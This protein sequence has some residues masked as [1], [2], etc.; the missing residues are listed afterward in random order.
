MGAELYNLSESRFYLQKE[1]AHRGET[2]KWAIR[3]SSAEPLSYVHRS[4]LCVAAYPQT[5]QRY[6]MIFELQWVYVGKVMI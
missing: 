1:T 2:Y 3:L 5:V 4:H 6:V